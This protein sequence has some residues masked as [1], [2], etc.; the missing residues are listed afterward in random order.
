MHDLRYAI[1]MLVKNRGL[2]AAAIVSL[3]LGIGANAVIFSWVKAV[4]LYP[5][6]GVAHQGDLIAVATRT[7]DGGY[8][9]LS[10]PDYRDYRDSTRTLDG[11]VVTETTALSLGAMSEAE[12]AER[13]YGALVS[14]NYFAVIGVA[15]ALGRTFSPDD[16]RVPNGSPIVV[17]SDGLWHRRYAGDPAIVGRTIAI[18]GHP[19]T[20]VGVM[21]AT[22]QGTMVGIALDV[23][24]PVMMQPQILPGGDRLEARGLRWLE[25]M[26]RLKPG[27]SIQ[28]AQSDLEAIGHR[29]IAA[30]PRSNEG[31]TPSVLPLSKSPWGAQL[32][33]G[34]VLTVLTAVVATVLLLACA[35]VANL[36]LAR[37]LARRREVAI[38][39]AIGASRARLVRQF[40]IESLL[41]A[42]LGG[43][44]GF[45]IARM[46]AGVLTA[47]TPP[48]DI[49]VKLTIG[50][51]LGVLAFTGGLALVTGFVFG[52][53]PALQGTRADVVADLK[54][55]AGSTGGRARARLRHGLVIVQVSLSVLMLVAAGLFMRS[56]TNAQQMSPGFNASGVLLAAYDLFPNGYDAGS[57][58]QFHD[59]LVEQIGGLPGVSTAALARRVPLGFD[60]PPSIR[61]R[62]DGYVPA[63][64][65]SMQIDYDVI[66]PDYFRTLEIPI[67]SGRAFT[68][69]DDEKAPRVV[70]VNAAMAR[71]YWT[72]TDV[73]GR[74]LRI[75]DQALEIV[76]VVPTGKYR[77]LAEQARPFMYM[78]ARQM[79]A[80][81][82]VFYVR[83]DG[84]P[85]ALVS[86]VRAAVG[87][88]DPNL[89]LFDVRT[90]Q[91]HMAFATVTPRLAASLLGA[92]GV[93]ALV[94]A[95][96]GLHSVLAYTVSQRTREVAIRLAL[97]AGPANVR[98]LVVRQGMWLLAAGLGI[99]MAIAYGALP[100]MSPLLIGISAK[101]PLTFSAVGALL[102][103]VA[104]GASYLPARSVS[105]VDPIATLRQ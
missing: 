84:N 16:D 32:V 65:E 35:N 60:R 99:G 74:R 48:T 91:T 40:L 103:V 38:R 61:I 71:R 53:V 18:N 72:Q 12:R 93:L 24:V 55:E 21:P 96:V 4:L 45:L 87:A 34:P 67:V 57:G 2:A 25:G 42:I 30:Y 76:G 8:V 56:F 9:N 94:L 101:D 6:P 29:L 33:L 82:M 68:S 11:L 54:D 27:V 102:A 43:G 59:R 78:P 66:S 49:P 95:A 58:R 17:I 15:P 79:Y 104:L 98:G 62:I 73:V 36:L 50:V 90:L 19:L 5:L 80:P 46:A 14:G 23:W 64:D 22:F 83:A 88:L 85:A 1:R 47:F 100:L 63:P 37:A 70:I 69:R 97:G 52:L 44:A 26:A 39:L 13:L 20:V 31:F 28:S 75:A 77:T 7:R 89:P 41:L 10:Y 3:G 81:Q 51:D 86:S 105:R 92:F